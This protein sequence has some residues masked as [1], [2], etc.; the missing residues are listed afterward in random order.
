M[1]GVRLSSSAGGE[2]F[3]RRAAKAIAAALEGATSAVVATGRTPMGAYARLGADLAPGRIDH[4]RVFQ[5]DEYV[6]VGPQDRRSLAA[7]MRR[8]FVDPLGI[9]PSRI[10]W[11]DGLAEDLEASCSTYEDAVANAGGFDLAVLGIG[12]NGHLGFNEPPADPSSPT[13]VVR[14]SET[15]LRSNAVSGPEL[16]VPTSART[17][18]LDL[19]RA[20]RRVVLLVSGR[21]KRDIVHRAF[22]RPV[23]PDVPASF[24]Q[25]HPNVELVVDA[26]AWGG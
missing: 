7:W 14:L 13:R 11:L 23:T 18:G 21:A 5:L 22:E 8:S 17:A 15:S 20:A 3:D 10:V 16:E 4:L 9:D 24:L 1:T 12:P 2:A 6:G 19:L 25:E 26:D